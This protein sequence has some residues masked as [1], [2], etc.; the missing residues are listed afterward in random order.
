VV[1]V[2]S[3]FTE[4]KP[5]PTTIHALV[6]VNNEETLVDID[7]ERA[8]S[9]VLY[10]LERDS[11]T[12]TT[13]SEGPTQNDDTDY[14]GLGRSMILGALLFVILVD[15]YALFSTRWVRSMKVLALAALLLTFMLFPFMYAYELGGGSTDNLANESPGNNLE[16]VS[17]VHTTTTSSADI[18]WIG[19][20]FNSQFEGF[21]LGLLDKSERP[22]VID[23]APN[24]TDE[25]YRS[26]ISLESKFDVRFGK[27]I[28]SIFIIP[29][30]WVLLRTPKTNRHLL[31]EE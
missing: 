18:V 2:E 15:I 25:A 1:E 8:T 4:G 31:E 30:I 9:L 21:D 13:K 24:E 27:N 20:Q 5:A 22:Q 29:L 6:V 7:V 3:Q 23:Q 12:T 28:D 26:F 11:G 17:F 10:T 19:V 14:L 16:T